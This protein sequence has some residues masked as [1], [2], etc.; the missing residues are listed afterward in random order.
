MKIAY[1]NF[2]QECSELAPGWT[3]VD[4]F[5]SKNKVVDHN[6]HKYQIITKATRHDSLLKR[7]ACI[8]LSILLVPLLFES[9]RN[10]V[11]KG[12][13]SIH[14]A[15]PV[16]D[17][18]KSKKMD[19]LMDAVWN[20]KGTPGILRQKDLSEAGAQKRMWK[21]AV[22]AIKEHAKEEGYAYT[23]TKTT[24]RFEN[25]KNSFNEM[26]NGS[27]Q[28]FKNILPD[29][30]DLQKLHKHDEYL[31]KQ[32]TGGPSDQFN[33]ITKPTPLTLS[34]TGAA[35][36]GH[37]RETMEDAHFYTEISQGTLSG[38]FD[39]HGGKEIAEYASKSFEKRFEQEL[40]TANGNV[41]VAFESLFSQIQHEVA[42]CEPLYNMGST[43][44]VTFIDKKTNI[45]YTATLGDSE[46]NIY[47]MIDGKMKSIPLSC[48]RDWSS[49]KD[50]ARAANVLNEP[51]IATEWPKA[52]NPK[53]LRFPK[54]C[55][56]VARAFGDIHTGYLMAGPGM[57]HKP[58]I[59]MNK[60]EKGDVV[61]LA[62]DGLKDYVP[63]KVIAEKVA[64]NKDNPKV[65]L[66]QEL[67]NYAISP[68]GAD[69]HDNVTVV[70]IKA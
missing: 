66:A 56:N 55:V 54:G 63:E 26:I 25:W 19:D 53:E 47:R 2:Q 35:A 14:Y 8:I 28:F 37:H 38:V 60:L 11:F 69:A 62:C 27:N 13:E 33:S 67:V 5:K 44:V 49:P 64:A 23:E 40:T 68:K 21:N 16:C 31:L 3:K 39:G 70:A 20:P 9:F 52:E 10:V 59:T 4:Q 18:T 22:K 36:Q 6:N 48:V 45:I 46:A 7:I 51:S 58:K 29:L 43:A 57:I 12:K 61:V 15:V 24:S 1:I 30:Y 50:A 41:L 17:P 34:H 65:N 32:N 42:K